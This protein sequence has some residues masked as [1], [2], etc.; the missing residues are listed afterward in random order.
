[1]DYVG[2]AFL[3]ALSLLI[4][5]GPGDDATGSVTIISAG[6]SS[7][8]CSFPQAVRNSS[9][10]YSVKVTVTDRWNAAGHGSGTS[11]HT[12]TVGPNRTAGIGCQ[13]TSGAQVPTTRHEYSIANAVFV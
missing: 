7:M 3:S 5:A 8:T 1:M 12:Y 4:S 11:N 9:S 13:M 2:F 6:A 10:R